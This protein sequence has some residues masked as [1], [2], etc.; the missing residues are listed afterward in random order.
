MGTLRRIGRGERHAADDGQRE[1]HRQ[2]GAGAEHPGKLLR[3]Q[4]VE[5]RRG[6]DEARAREVFGREAGDVGSPGLDG[7]RGAWRVGG[8]EFEQVGVAGRCTTQVLRPGQPR[9]EPTAH[10]AA[11]APQVVDHERAGGEP[12]RE[13]LG[14]L[15]RACG[16]VGGLAQGQP[17][18]ADA[19]GLRAH[20]A[21]PASAAATRSWSP[22]SRAASRGAPRAARRRRPRSSAS[23]SHR[24]SAAPRAAASP[25]GISSPGRVP[26]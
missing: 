8:D 4:Q 15:A 16:R 7:D 22:A 12:L 13:A 19:D 20:R 18:G 14:E 6:D 24:R 2:P 21:A 26:S 23:P 11:A 10:R 9:G 5:Q 3:G 25:G 17:A 1:Q